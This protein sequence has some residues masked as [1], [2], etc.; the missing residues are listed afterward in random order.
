M[1][2]FQALKVLRTAEF[3]PY[4]IFIAAPTITP[5]LNEVVKS[6]VPLYLKRKNLV[7]FS[8]SPPGPSALS[9]LCDVASIYKLFL[10][11]FV[12]LCMAVP[13][14]LV[15]E[16]LCKLHSFFWSSFSFLLQL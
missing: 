1:F 6:F 7:S 15:S 16:A 4:V 5:S 3:A 12:L 10:C 8:S 14:T 11:S 2:V 13:S 9:L